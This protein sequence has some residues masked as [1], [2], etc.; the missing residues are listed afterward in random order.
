MITIS[1]M[2]IYIVFNTFYFF[3]YHI[4]L[5]HIF[6][7]G[8]IALNNKN[9]DMASLMSILSKMDKKQL[10]EGLSK[11]SQILQSNNKDEILRKIN[12]N[13]KNKVD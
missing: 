5:K 2:F 6:N 8:G 4:I 3:E 10:E 1:F 13:Q 12:S 9:F 11:A 7:L